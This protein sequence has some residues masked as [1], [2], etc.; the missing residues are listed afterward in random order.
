MRTG[1]DGDRAAD[2]LPIPPSWGV[3]E[4][5]CFVAVARLL[6]SITGRALLSC[7]SRIAG[8]DLALQASLSGGTRIEVLFQA[9]FPS[10]GAYP[11]QRA[12]SLSRE[13]R[14]DIVLV[15]ERN[16]H[17]RLMVLDAKWRSGR[18]NL[19]DAMTSAHVYHDSLRIDSSR[20]D[21]SLLLVPGADEPSL[22][23]LGES[24]F[25]ATHGVGA[26]SRF[27][28]GDSGIEQCRGVLEHWLAACGHV[29]SDFPT[30]G[31]R[32]SLAGACA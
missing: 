10:G 30:D 6:G 17:R 3:Y 27:R 14:P 21:M 12:W 13:R 16:G 18:E 20:P 29:P 4:T 7:G 8:A 22:G 19:L 28:P 15:A 5:W 23:Y 26:L 9:T 32:S 31:G 2:S 24:A 11:H 25:R 1:I